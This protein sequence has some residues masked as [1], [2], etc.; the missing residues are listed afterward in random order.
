M[1]RPTQIITSI[2]VQIILFAGSVNSVAANDPSL[3][4]YF[5]MELTG[6]AITEAVSGKS[7][8]VQN[9]FSKPE[10]IPGAEGNALRLDGYST[11]S[12]TQFNVQNLSTTGLTVSLWCAMETYPVISP[13]NYSSTSTYIAGNMRDDLKTGFAFTLNNAGRYAFEVYINGVK[14][15][16]YDA[17]SNLP[18]YEW[19]HLTATVNT[20]TQQV[21]LFRN[22]ELVARV[23]FAGTSINTG[24]SSFIIGKSF[25]DDKVGIFRTNV[26]NGLVDDIRIFS[27]T[28]ADT[29]IVDQTPQNIA[30][31]SIPKSRHANDIQR[32]EF[33]GQPATNWTNEPHGFVFYNNKYHVFFQ[34]NANGPY[35]ARL[36][37]G[38]ISSPDMLNWTEEKIAIGP[39]ETY[40]SKGT[41]SGCVFTD[42]V[43]TGGL[44]TI[45][46]TGVDYAKASMNKA[47]PTDNGLIDWIKDNANPLVP[48]KPTG[49]SDDFRDPCV[50]KSNGE[51]YMIVGTSKNGLG[52]TTLHK[53]NST[54]KT[55]SN[56]GKIFYQS[57]STNYGTFWEMPV[58]T[59]MPEGKWLFAT[60]PLG[61]S[62]GVETLYW[63]GTINTDGTFNP[64]SSTP[65]EVELGAMGKDGYGLLSPSIMHKDGKTI[66]IGI[67]PD[68]LPAAN[69]LQLGWA[70]LYSLPREWSLSATNNL[71]QQPY[72]GTQNMR[73]ASS[74]INISNEDVSGTLSLAPIGGKAVEI[75]GSFIVSGAQNFGF[76][77]RKSGSNYISIHY[78]PTTNTFTVDARN[79]SR[80]SNDV[81]GY[82][83]L[84]ESTL[85]VKPAVGDT[86]RIHIFIDHSIMDIFVNNQYAFSIRVFPTDTNAEDVEA[87]SAGGST[88]AVSIQ[89]WKL[90][91]LQGFTEVVSH[92][93]DINIKM[94]TKNGDLFY[95]NVPA[96]SKI[97]ILNLNGQIVLID[98]CKSSS[99]SIALKSNMIY[100][101]QISSSEYSTARKII[102]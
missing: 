62:N 40:D 68:K 8:I 82:N 38:H 87:F 15:T 101:A 18:K 86:M 96:H 83:G 95:E 33:H 100:I 81:G 23:S 45:F 31:L 91:S 6:N 53:Y 34:K 79:I 72:A 44:P 60:T 55:W 70:H 97:V 78:T 46:Y 88:H 5:P 71:I 25:A 22:A 74:S 13:D 3:V 85:P 65:K 48:N 37:W 12:T 98:Y 52:A 67:V 99:G 50:F 30:D 32:P 61:G 76:H 14:I 89:A 2:F 75:D 26:I 73:V 47:T 19:A 10:N 102:T 28:F 41:W 54:L 42:D 20:A 90:N 94:Y 4:A 16:C 51:L 93:S 57:S 59:P 36:H 77:V 1:N 7:Y 29:E 58:I 64:F 27:R 17:Y 69:N 84:Y 11:Y 80:L 35:M 39:S 21:K 56:D 66:A 43:F 9:N 92:R 24:S 49:L 63:V